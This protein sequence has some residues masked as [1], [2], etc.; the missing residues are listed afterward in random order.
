MK[1]PEYGR[2]KTG[3]DESKREGAETLAIAA[4]S[5]LASEPERFDRFLSLIGIGP[6]DVREAAQEPHFLAGVL[7]HISSDEQMLVEFAKHA[8]IKPAEV[9]HARAA[10]GGVWERD[11]P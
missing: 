6:G 7:E 10:L 5:F 3:K 2:F 4:L 1:T 8:E 11:I 9:E